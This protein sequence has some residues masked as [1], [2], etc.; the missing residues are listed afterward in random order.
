MSLKYEGVA[1]DVYTPI[2][3]LIKVNSKTSQV[4]L[5]YL[6]DRGIKLNGKIT[7]K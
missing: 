4:K 6:K 2:F 3:G 5:K 7:E 1:C